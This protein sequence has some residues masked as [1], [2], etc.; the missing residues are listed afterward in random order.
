MASFSGTL[1]P[2]RDGVVIFVNNAQITPTFSVV[3]LSKECSI[4]LRWEPEAGPGGS[5]LPQGYLAKGQSAFF[6]I[7]S[8]WFKITARN[9]SR[10]FAAKFTV[11]IEP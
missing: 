3:N 4:D 8:N 10:D 11:F 9:T 1:P 7:R 5:V 2:K 6:N